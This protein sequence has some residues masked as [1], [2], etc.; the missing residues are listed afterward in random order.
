MTMH[1]ALHPR[2][3]V[4][5]C[6]EKREEEGLPALKIELTYQYN[7]SKTTSKALK[8]TDYSH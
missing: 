2:Y 1:K 6:Q 3:N 7:E 5:I 4:D 8:K